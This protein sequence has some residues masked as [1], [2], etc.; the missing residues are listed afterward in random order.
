M[1]TV[2]TQDLLTMVQSK[3]LENEELFSASLVTKAL[4]GNLEPFLVRINE[5]NTS[6]ALAKK[7]L[8]MTNQCNQRYRGVDSSVINAA[9]RVILDDI[10]QF[11][12]QYSIDSSSM[13]KKTNIGDR[14]PCYSKVEC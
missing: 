9:C 7:I 11:L 13:L 12:V 2:T 3:L 8:N 5:V 14:S 6:K 10:E 1:S 4:H